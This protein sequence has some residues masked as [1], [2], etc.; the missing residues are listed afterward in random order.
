MVQSQLIHTVVE[1]LWDAQ[2]RSFEGSE[3][4]QLADLICDYEGKSWDSYFNEVD[5]AS[6]DFMAEREI[7]IEQKGAAKAL[8]KD[9]EVS[10]SFNEEESFEST[11]EE[12]IELKK[13]VEQCENQPEIEVD[14]DNL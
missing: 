14:I 9:S 5:A 10:K 4:H 1:Q 7:I 13:V 12:D 3:L 8:I 11:M 2:Y 6:D